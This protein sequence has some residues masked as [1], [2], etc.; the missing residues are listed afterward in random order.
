M[1]DP[2]AITTASRSRKSIDP[3]RILIQTE[4][5]IRFDSKLIAV[6]SSSRLATRVTRNS[7]TPKL[8]EVN[9]PPDTGKF[10]NVRR[11]QGG[12]GHRAE[13]ILDGTFLA[14]QL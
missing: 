14:G 4:M 3:R 1:L 13:G 6:H 11:C 8:F 7:I 5:S 10:V 2:E 12:P 9:V